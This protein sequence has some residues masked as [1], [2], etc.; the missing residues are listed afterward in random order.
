MNSPVGV[1][2]LAGLLRRCAA[3]LSPHSSCPALHAP[4]PSWAT[5][6]AGCVVQCQSAPSTNTDVQGRARPPL[7]TQVCLQG[8]GPLQS[9]GVQAGCVMVLP[10][11]VQAR[12]AHEEAVEANAGIWWQGTLQ[13]VPLQEGLAQQ[14]GIKRHAD[15]VGEHSRQCGT[16]PST[17]LHAAPWL[18]GF[19]LLR[20]AVKR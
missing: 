15:K 2:S 8:E 14:R 11:C 7:P 5:Q 12:L 18:Q 20:R 1:P 13:A 10:C 16:L 6:I 4:C 3:S 9:T 19:F 17:A